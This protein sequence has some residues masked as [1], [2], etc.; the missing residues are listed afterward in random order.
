[1][2]KNTVRHSLKGK[3]RELLNGIDPVNLLAPQEKYFVTLA[4]EKLKLAEMQQT[5]V[6]K[7]KTIK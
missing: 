3:E 4:H 6:H 7:Q 5:L 2:E 1:M